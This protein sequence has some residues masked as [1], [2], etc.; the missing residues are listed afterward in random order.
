MR[1]ILEFDFEDYHDKMAHK[2][3]ISATDVY[4]A[5]REYSEIIRRIEKYEN[6]NDDQMQILTDLKN[7][8][9]QVLEDNEINLEDLE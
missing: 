1:A 4:I 7:S 9:Y 8:F 3:A 6:L 5:L 2:R